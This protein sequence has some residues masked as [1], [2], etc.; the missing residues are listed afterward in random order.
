[1]DIT[2]PNFINETQV[3][4]I[5]C[6][7][8]F[9]CPAY[10]YCYD[11]QQCLCH[12]FYAR[13][14]PTVGCTQYTTPSV[15]ILRFFTLLT[16]FMSGYFTHR[17]VNTILQLKKTYCLKMNASGNIIIFSTLSQ[18]SLFCSILT[19]TMN[20]FSQDPNYDLHD[21]FLIIMFMILSTTFA[22]AMAS[23]P[24]MW[25]TCVQRVVHCWPEDTFRNM[26]YLFRSICLLNPVL[27]LY[28]MSGGMWAIAT[29]WFMLQ[30]IF[31]AVGFR[32]A[33]RKLR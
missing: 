33:G 29:G 6:L 9:D 17:C 24:I 5:T 10:F 28:F 18:I 4:A 11:H 3:E 23:V 26:M 8:E 15:Y 30:T 25:I 27:F 7:G 13:L 19:Y 22:Y 1:M 2:R 16:F 32:G 14:N 31:F 12:E 21:Q 20:L